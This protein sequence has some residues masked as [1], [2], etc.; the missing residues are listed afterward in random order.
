[1][2]GG[3]FAADGR[4]TNPHVWACSTGDE[5]ARASRELAER[6]R[7][8]GCL[9]PAVSCRVDL[10]NPSPFEQASSP[11]LANISIRSR[12]SSMLLSNLELFGI[13]KNLSL[14]S[15]LLQIGER[16]FEREIFSNTKQ[17]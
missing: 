14:K 12:S 9:G 2:K 7:D 15:S 5:P 8:L 10:F 11:A 16:D 13:A 17:L 6:E 3:G 4:R 1:M